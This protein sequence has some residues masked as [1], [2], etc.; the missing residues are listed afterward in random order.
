MPGIWE[1]K[2]PII[3]ETK[4]AY[5]KFAHNKAMFISKHWFYDFAN[6]RRDGYDFDA[7]FEDHLATYPE[8]YLYNIIASKH[9]IRSKE[10][11]AIGG[12]IKPKGKGKDEWIP[13]KGFDSTITKLQMK[14]YVL[15]TDFDY[16]QDKNGHFYGWGMARYAT[17]EN[18]YGEAFSKKVYARS[19]QESKERIMKH[20]KKLLPDTPIRELEYFL[21]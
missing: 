11:K 6:Y 4:C 14:G 5:G 18:F 3:Q 9:F 7:R 20:L 10:A 12:Y 16:A 21:Q 13:R 19:P 8:Q 17:P 1:W 15:I 2:G